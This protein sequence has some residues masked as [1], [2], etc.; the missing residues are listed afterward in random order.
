[1]K[2]FIS[3]LLMGKIV[4]RYKSAKAFDET[5]SALESAIAS[6]GFS[7]VAVHDMRSTYQEKGLAIDDDFQYRIYHLCNAPKSHKALTTMSYDLGVMMP[8]SIIVAREKGETTLRFM[9]MKPWMVSLMFP[10]IDLV[11]MSKMV[12]ATMEKIVLESIK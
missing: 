3:S 7:I 2:K 6:N 4:A 11:P 1:M 9:K 12:T 10:E 5:V 8:K